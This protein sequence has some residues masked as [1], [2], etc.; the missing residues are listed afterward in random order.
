MAMREYRLKERLRLA[1]LADRHTDIMLKRI[2]EGTVGVAEVQAFSAMKS[3]EADAK[4]MP[5][6]PFDLKVA[7][8]FVASHVVPLISFMLPAILEWLGVSF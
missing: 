1:A 8:Y 5:L 2:D 7:F 3:V 6:W 4:K